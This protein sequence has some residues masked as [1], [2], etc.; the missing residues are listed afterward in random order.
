MKRL[1]YLVGMPLLAIDK[2]EKVGEF[3]EGY[4]ST[5]EHKLAGLILR[6]A[7]IISQPYGVLPSQVNVGESAI[8]LKEKE[9]PK[10][11]DLHE[12]CLPYARIKEKPIY[13]K[14]G[15]NLGNIQDVL[16]L[17]ETGQIL[18]FEVSDGVVNDILNGRGIIPVPSSTIYGKDTIVVPNE[19][20][21]MAKEQLT[22]QDLKKYIN[23]FDKNETLDNNSWDTVEQY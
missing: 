4:I 2:G 18:G 9:K 5:L 13:S 19:V 23:N 16:F 14:N 20:I 17:K 3:C 6:K 10:I 8:V 15:E 12:H 22:L 11:L 21:D 1:N 7:S